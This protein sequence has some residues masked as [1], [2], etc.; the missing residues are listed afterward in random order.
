[1]D[2]Y[3]AIIAVASML[4]SVYIAF[5]MI[6]IENR[7]AVSNKTDNFCLC[8]KSELDDDNPPLVEDAVTL[9]LLELKT[10]IHSMPLTVR[11]ETRIR[12]FIDLFCLARAYAVEEDYSL[13]LILQDIKHVAREEPKFWAVFDSLIDDYNDEFVAFMNT[14][15]PQ[16]SSTAEPTVE[17]SDQTT[18]QNTEP[19]SA[20]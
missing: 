17:Q 5:K 16:A 9:K 20:V 3:F 6:D 19:T 15:R 8:N 12:M 10:M 4:L 7:F 1:V 11:P 13:S 2:I 14:E 18:Q